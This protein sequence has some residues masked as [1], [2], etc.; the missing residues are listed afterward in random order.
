MLETLFYNFKVI[1]RNTIKHKRFFLISI[2]SLAI[3]IATSC[4][5]WIHIKYEKSYDKF[6]EQT[7]NL[8]RVTYTVH[9]GG[10]Q[11]VNS[12]RTQSALSWVL[13]DETDLIVASSRA[14]YEDCYMYTDDVKLFNQ[15]VVWA[16]SSF[17][18]VFQ[19]EM[20]LG[21]PRTA[22]SNKYTVVISDKVAKIYFGNENPLGKIIK[23]NS[24]LPFN[25]TGVFKA[26]PDNSHLRYDFVTSFVTQEDY[27]LPRQ[28]SWRANWISTYIRKRDNV[29]PQQI[30]DVLS[31]LTHKYM[32][33]KMSQGQEITLTL[34][35]VKNIYLQSNL[36]GEF[37]PMGSA[38]KISLLTVISLFVLVIAWANNVNISTALSFERAKE[39]GVRKLIG[40]SNK[41][42]FNYYITESFF[43]NSIAIL[44]SFIFIWIS[45]S[46]FKSLVDGSIVKD[47]YFQSWFW[48]T[49]LAFLIA[50]VLFTGVVPAIIQSSFNPLQILKNYANE[51]SNLKI[52]RTNLAIFQFAIAIILVAS[53]IVIS[54]QIKFL[55][56]QD[57]G[58]NAE[59]VFVFRAPATNN[60]TG[61]KRYT[62][63]CAFREELLKSPYFKQLTATMNIPGQSNKFKNR[64]VSRNGKEI[65]ASFNLAQSD[66]HYFETYQVPIIE[67]RN[68]YSN[69]DNE[70]GSVIINEVASQALGFDTPAGAVGQKIRMR[71]SDKLI[72]GVTKN[73]HHESL[74]MQLEPYI[75][76][77]SHPREFGY[78]P[79]LVETN[80]LNAA[81]NYA[82]K[83]WKNHYQEAL[84]DGFF[85][86]K[87]FN[88]QYISFR[89]LGKLVGA[90]SV[91]SI[92]IAC[93][94]LFAL[95]SNI[96]NKRI[97]EIGVRKVNG[98]KVSQ[99]LAILNKD[100]VTWVTVA[101]VIACPLAWF[102][103]NRWLQN[104]AYKTTLSWWIFALA[105]VLALAI[106]LLTVS[107]QSWKAAVRNPIESLRY[108]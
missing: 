106:A 13:P 57:L 94:G 21:D 31:Q 89:Q 50:G 71:N 19:N 63:F 100:F 37:K 34:L 28:G 81:I 73:F 47:F 39:S 36:E 6:Y 78:Y 90:C 62:D 59:Q 24:G 52:F 20:L 64:I 29:T 60:T 107:F 26:L 65:D 22:L 2:F 96:V 108:E 80:N 9:Q 84:F 1:L 69:M 11:I 12:C 7:D 30:E 32:E 68:F 44:L 93:L 72:I 67:G 74:Q 51:R 25:V 48:I 83:V 41:S 42:I 49:I 105:G 77:F 53:T 104:F 55:E 82:E 101:F 86:D 75:Y 98:A 14:Y 5:L 17:F 46:T 58:V 4:L 40:A 8:Y 61:K 70:R 27:G 16:D 56:K 99:I 102:A 18:N 92:L 54:K 95:A 33:A 43:I 103:M 85:L 35:P 66:D 3:G 91:L 45:L 10:K 15:K 23:L 88:K 38:T 87:Y 76:E 97:K 79:A